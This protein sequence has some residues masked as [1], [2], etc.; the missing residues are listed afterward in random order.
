VGD[1]KT[2]PAL[3]AIDQE[4]RRY[5]IGK[6]YRRREVVWTRG[7]ISEESPHKGPSRDFVVVDYVKGD[8]LGSLEHGVQVWIDRDTGERVVV[9]KAAI[10]QA[11]Q[12]VLRAGHDLTE[13]TWI[14]EAVGDSYH[15]TYSIRP[16]GPDVYISGGAITV[17]IDR[18]TLRPVGKLLYQV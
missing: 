11:H 12:A 10:R 13:Y 16:S 17:K 6:G 2:P 9:P 3:A 18:R 5:G 1:P 8:S 14:V 7:V 15:F 4:V